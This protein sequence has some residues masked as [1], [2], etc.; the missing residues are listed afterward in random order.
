MVLRGVCEPVNRVWQGQGTTLWKAWLSNRIPGS[1]SGL[2][3]DTRL[4]DNT[5]RRDVQQVTG[6]H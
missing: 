4:G 5:G 2:R 6:S 3:T 1:G